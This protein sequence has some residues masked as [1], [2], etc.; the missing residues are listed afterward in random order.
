M[1]NVGRMLRTLHSGSFTVHSVWYVV[2]PTCVASGVE[3]KGIPT[4]GGGG[5]ENSCPDEAMVRRARH[6][7][8]LAG[9]FLALI[10]TESRANE[11]LTR[12]IDCTNLGSV[13]GGRIQ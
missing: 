12:L 3:A 8:Y 2:S 1:L 6:S 10:G 5:G 9:L 7:W 13:L 11:A 4:G